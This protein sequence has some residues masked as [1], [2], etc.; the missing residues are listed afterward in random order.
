[1]GAPAAVSRALDLYSAFVQD[2]IQLVRNRLRLT[3]GTKLEHNAYTGRS[4]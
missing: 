1:M 3:L 2:D 4:K